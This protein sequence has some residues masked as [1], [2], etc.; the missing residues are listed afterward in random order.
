MEKI[1]VVEDNEEYLMLLKKILEGEG[2][3]VDS[4]VT[5]LAALE[6]LAKNN[7]SLI[8]SDLY[9]QDID[10]IALVTTA[11]RIDPNIRTIILTGQ[12]HEDTELVAIES[13]VDLY[14]SKEKSLDLVLRYVA[15]LMKDRTYKNTGVILE[16]R[17]QNIILNLKTHEVKKNNEL[18]ELTPIEFEIL[19]YFLESMNVRLSREEI[20]MRV[21]GEDVT[22]SRVVDV[23]VKNLR[24]KLSIFSITTIRGYGYKWNEK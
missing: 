10:G 1:L 23:H 19:Q 18:I 6:F 21:W 9:M 22:S 16:S 8:I 4:A 13:N 11:K 3:I 2:Y 24:D 7:Y 15:S 20:I 5:S 12:P 17:S 14:L